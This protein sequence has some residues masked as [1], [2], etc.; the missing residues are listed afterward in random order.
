VG[1][2]ASVIDIGPTIVD[3]LGLGGEPSQH[4]SSLLRSEERMALFHADYAS[5]WLGL[6]DRCWKSLYEIEAKRGQLYDVCVDP[7][8]TQDLASTHRARVE[9]Y[10]DHLLAW[11]AAR[12]GAVLR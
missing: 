5:G 6:R 10:R 1:Q 9:T 2:V 8:E 3:L 4:G 12:R 7:D 11:S